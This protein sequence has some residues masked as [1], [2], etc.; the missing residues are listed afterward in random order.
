M[1]QPTPAPQ[2]ITLSLTHQGYGSSIEI[3]GKKISNV[4]N[5]QVRAGVDDLTT[6]TLEITG[7][8]DIDADAGVFYLISNKFGRD[9]DAS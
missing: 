9:R 4:R 1:K 8:V 3:D 2:K 7:P 6:V 5:I